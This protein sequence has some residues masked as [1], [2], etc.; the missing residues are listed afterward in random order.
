MRKKIFLPML[1]VLV[2]LS[3]AACG[4][5]PQTGPDTSEKTETVSLPDTPTASAA[6]K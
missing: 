4:T 5:L 6:V 2:L 1:G 3:L